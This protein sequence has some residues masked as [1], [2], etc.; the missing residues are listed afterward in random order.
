[1]QAHAIMGADWPA[2]VFFHALRLIGPA[3]VV[4]TQNSG[5][6]FGWTR[7]FLSILNCE[8]GLDSGALG[9]QTAFGILLSR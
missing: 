3:Y 1:M 8:K 9:V 4:Q 2:A 6:Q 5:P 7:H